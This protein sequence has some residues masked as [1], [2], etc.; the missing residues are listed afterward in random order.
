MSA[1][2]IN[3]GQ[4]QIPEI[5]NI[6]KVNLDPGLYIVATPIGNIADIT[7]RALQTLQSADYIACEDSRVTN[8]LLSYY[9]I[10][11]SMVIYNDHSQQNDRDRIINLIQNGKSVALVSDAGTPLISDPGYKLVQAVKENNLYITTCPGPSSTIS[12][13]VLSGLPSNEFLFMGFLNHKSGARTKQLQELKL[14]N[15]T[16]IIFESANRLAA[17]LHGINTILGNRVIS[18]VREISKLFEESKTETVLELIKYYEDNKARGEII[19]IISADNNLDIIES[20]EALDKQLSTLL[21][22]HSVKDAVEIIHKQ[23]KLAKRDLYK[24]ALKLQK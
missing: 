20:E 4:M 11:A 16:A 23:S 12:A 22:D 21:H 24:R 18:V 1:K 5:I 9:N 6:K 15:K 2:I 14:I 8:K 10:K 17:T 7:I 13:L 19:I 3:V